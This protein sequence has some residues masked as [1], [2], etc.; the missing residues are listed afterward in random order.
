MSEKTVKTNLPAEEPLTIQRER[1]LQAMRKC[2]LASEVLGLLFPE[3]T[4]QLIEHGTITRVG[5]STYLYL[6]AN[7]LRGRIDMNDTLVCI[8]LTSG[9]IQTGTYRTLVDGDEVVGVLGNGYELQPIRLGRRDEDEE[10]E[11]D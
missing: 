11:E 8:A 3:L 10:E 7:L 9:S 2:S 6:D 4:A 1:V 5:E